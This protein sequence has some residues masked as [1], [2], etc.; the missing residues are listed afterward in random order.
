MPRGERQ[1]W[2]WG[3]QEKGLTN[4]PRKLGHSRDIHCLDSGDSF[5]CLCLCWNIKSYILNMCSSLYVSYTSIK[6][7]QSLCQES[8]MLTISLILFLSKCLE[9]VPFHMWWKLREHVIA[10]VITAMTVMPFGTLGYIWVLYKHPL[11]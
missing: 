8:E 7:L 1:R 5:L 9:N 11:L 2:G 10:R 4:G 3:K 6:L